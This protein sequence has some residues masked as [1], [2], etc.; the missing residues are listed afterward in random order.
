MSVEL[1]DYF[2]DTVTVNTPSGVHLEPCGFEMSLANGYKKL[3]TTI[4]ETT[5]TGKTIDGKVQDGLMLGIKSRV[6]NLRSGIRE[7]K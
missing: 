1:T 5:N 2:G 3:F 4:Q 7:K 6:D